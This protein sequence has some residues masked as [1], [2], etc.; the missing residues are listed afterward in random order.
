MVSVPRQMRLNKET[1]VSG[2]GGLRLAV[3]GWEESKRPKDWGYGAPTNHP[4]SGFPLDFMI[5]LRVA[6]GSPGWPVAGLFQFSPQRSP[7]FSPP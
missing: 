6:G 3:G 7:P 1:A 4:I 2:I 5:S